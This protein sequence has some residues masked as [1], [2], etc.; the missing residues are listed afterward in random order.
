M[1]FSINS[2]SSALITLS[3]EPFYATALVNQ[4]KVLELRE[5]VKLYV[6]FV[7]YQLR[8]MYSCRIGSG[9]LLIQK[10]AAHISNTR[11][12]VEGKN[13]ICQLGCICHLDNVYTV[14]VASSSSLKEF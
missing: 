9:E 3:V 11:V 6:S 4:V 8:M 12:R 5:T 1:A 7:C 10:D 2:R 14:S 13:E